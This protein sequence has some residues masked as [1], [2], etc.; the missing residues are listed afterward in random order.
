[1][2]SK[3]LYFDIAKKYGKVASWA[4]WS[5]A[6]NSPKSN[7]SNMEIFDISKNPS[8]LNFLRN[9]IIMVGLNF[10]RPVE[11]N[12]PFSNFHDPNPNGQDYKIRYAFEHTDFYGS[13]MTD[14]IKNN[15]TSSSKDI[16]KHLKNKPH[17]IKYNINI[18]REELIF[19]GAIKP[20]IIAFGQDAHEIL[21][22]NLNNT[23]YSKLIKITHYSH[24]ISKENYRIDT[25]KKL[26]HLIFNNTNIIEK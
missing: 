24:R 26:E 3:K 14:V 17:E 6:E 8:I 16:I 5:K 20:I 23:E 13:Y 7:I 18:F 2:I 15:P 10:S 4:V 1:M 12:Q 25:H 22:K 9:D 11:I 21:N 19:I